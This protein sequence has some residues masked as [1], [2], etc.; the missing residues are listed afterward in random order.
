MDATI[1]LVKK[2]IHAKQNELKAKE[3]LKAEEMLKAKELSEAEQSK[4]VEAQQTAA[5]EQ[6]AAIESE[7]RAWFEHIRN[8]VG[9]FNGDYFEWK[10][11]RERYV[12]NVHGAST[13]DTQKLKALK[14]CCVG[15][16]AD[17]LKT[18]E[19]VEG[20]YAKAWEAQNGQYENKYNQA[21]ATMSKLLSVPSINK[22]SA[23]KA[24]ITMDVC[25]A[26]WKAYMEQDLGIFCTFVAI[27][28]MDYEIFP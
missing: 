14:M 25:V 22:Q 24:A 27:D 1:I 12:Q 10:G 16:A 8:S 3:M 21:Q 13:S 15:K 17:T 11:F 26:N 7:T 23:T 18:Y 2:I 19:L 20:N 5:Q 28:K 6:A 9:Q 4:S